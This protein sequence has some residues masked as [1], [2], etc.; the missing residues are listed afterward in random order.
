MSEKDDVKSEVMKHFQKI[1]TVYYAT[2]DGDMPRVRPMAL[3]Y[4]ENRFWFSTGTKNAKVK[5]I[6]ENKNS[7]FCLLV[8]QGEDSGCIRCAGESIIV[9][10]RKTKEQLADVM[11]FFEE[12]WKGADDP[13]YTLIEMVVRR[14]EYLKPGT[15]EIGRFTFA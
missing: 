13:D 11:P 15:Y 1:Q 12:F 8:G 5:Q 4:H 7:E 3:I 6:Q 9:K 14:V 10:D 2:C